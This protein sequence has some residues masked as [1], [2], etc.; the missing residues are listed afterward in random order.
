MKKLL[1]FLLVIAALLGGAYAF[2]YVNGIPLS[3]IAWRDINIKNV[4]NLKNLQ[5]LTP[6][7]VAAQKALMLWDSGDYEALYGMLSEDVR[8]SLTLEAFQESRNKLIMP[9]MLRPQIQDVE[10]QGQT[11]TVT[12]TTENLDIRSLT[13]D[14]FQ[15]PDAQEGRS[16]APK[17]K[18]KKDDGD[19]AAIGEKLGRQTILV[20]LVNEGGS[21][22]VSQFDPIT[23]AFQKMTTDRQ[24]ERDEAAA[25]R[26]AEGYRSKIAVS[27]LRAQAM[28]TYGPKPFIV[29]NLE[30]RGD[31]TVLKLGLRFTVRDE[32][33]K[34]IVEELFHPVVESSISSE[35][36]P[37][38][39]GDEMRINYQVDQVPEGWRD[40][41]DVTADIVEIKLAPLDRAKAEE[42]AGGDD[43]KA[44]LKK[45]RERE[46]AGSS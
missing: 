18:G 21:W 17:A 35:E 32:A 20:E 16:K 26:D 15:G 13:A 40:T 7:G 25:S 44:K 28:A 36:K 38:G 29:G 43:P 34:V 4:R 37:L 42:K 30:N 31:R 9:G 14:I 46:R 24:L 2:L 23:V 41:H 6:A 27:D 45:A 33:G 22:K 1:T 12:A 11:A 19:G 8:K 10:D 39:P 5:N 3:R